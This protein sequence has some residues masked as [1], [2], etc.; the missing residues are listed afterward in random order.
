[1]NL[2]FENNFLLI[3]VML[4]VAVLL[5]IVWIFLILRRKE[6]FPTELKLIEPKLTEEKRENS[7]DS[8]SLQ[9]ELRQNLK[10]LKSLQKISERK[11][12]DL[13]EEFLQSL[14][15]IESEQ[16]NI[17]EYTLTTELVSEFSENIRSF[18]KSEFSSQNEELATNLKEIN[19]KIE[20]NK[21]KEIKTQI[22]E[23]DNQINE[24]LLP[25][26]TKIEEIMTDS[27]DQSD[28]ITSILKIMKDMKIQTD[29]LRKEK[30]QTQAFSNPSPL[31]SKSMNSK[32]SSI[33]NNID[34]KSRN[35]S[36]KPKNKSKSRSKAKPQYKKKPN[37]YPTKGSMEKTSPN[38]N[39]K[40]NQ[41]PLPY[42]G[43][44]KKST[45]DRKPSEKRLD[46][47]KISEML[48]P[49][50]HKPQISEK[51]TYHEQVFTLQENMK[52]KNL[53]YFKKPH[54]QNFIKKLFFRGGRTKTIILVTT[55]NQHYS[56]YYL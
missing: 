48:V 12:D 52:K 13:H 29:F 35:F 54:I 40:I 20:N 38:N 3:S 5:F 22:N 49:L 56:L 16:K 27:I 55:D 24:I 51:L 46:K 42:Q 32:K 28:K 1:M 26:V 8:I 25:R 36:K 45:I 15:T 4:I 2:N 11:F 30:S 7:S 34:K 37:T 44:T 17:E 6:L 31:K 41:P 23:I 19:E 50:I 10:K 43:I 39:K 18:V 9:K 21:L 14:T 47:V 53:D 33:S